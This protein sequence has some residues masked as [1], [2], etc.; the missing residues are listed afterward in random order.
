MWRPN[1]RRQD[2]CGSC[3]MEQPLAHTYAAHQSL[4][5][6]IHIAWLNAAARPLI[7]KMHLN[8]NTSM[9]QA[10]SLSC[11]LTAIMRSCAYQAYKNGSTSCCRNVGF[12]G[13]ELLEPATSAL[14]CR[15]SNDVGFTFLSPGGAAYGAMAMH[16]VSMYLWV[17][18]RD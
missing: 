12:C 13:V 3:C 15:G 8:L 18:V 9:L 2:Q 10:Y 17:L 14:R 7:S 4:S 11:S 1:F 16:G 6:K 5:Q